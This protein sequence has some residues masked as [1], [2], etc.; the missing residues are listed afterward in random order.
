MVEIIL[1]FNNCLNI[2]AFLTWSLDILWASRGSLIITRLSIVILSFQLLN[3]GKQIL[4]DWF[5]NEFNIFVINTWLYPC[6]ILL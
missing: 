4:A 5:S 3:N 1:V 2:G 6:K